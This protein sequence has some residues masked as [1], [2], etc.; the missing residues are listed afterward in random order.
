MTKVLVMDAFGNAVR[1]L[2]IAFLLVL[3]ACDSSTDGDDPCATVPIS[4]SLD[5]I[6]YWGKTSDP[7]AWHVNTGVPVASGKFTQWLSAD[8]VVSATERLVGGVK[9]RG[10]IVFTLRPDG[11]SIDNWEWFKFDHEISLMRVF[12]SNGELW[13]L[14][15]ESAQETYPRLGRAVLANGNV[16]IQSVLLDETWR[17]WG[18]DEWSDGTSVLAHGR[19]PSDSTFGFFIVSAASDSLVYGLNISAEA[20]RGMDLSADGDRLY[21]GATIDQGANARTWIHCLDLTTKPLQPV[22]IADVS[23]ECLRVAINPSNANEVLVNRRVFQG[24]NVKEDIVE[25]LDVVSWKSQRIDVRT[26]QNPCGVVR[27]EYPFWRPDGAAIIF[28]AW[29]G[30]ADEPSRVWTRTVSP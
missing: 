25:L 14:Y 18:F 3:V 20:A 4:S 13:I 22:V 21:W 6:F 26:S 2:L 29:T 30:Q 27:N 15:F 19:R 23:G 9:E 1:L 10:L 24:V 16:E 28:R 8:Q 17:V 5:P 12:E 11:V 7:N